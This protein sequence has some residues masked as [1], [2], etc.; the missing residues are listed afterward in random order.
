MIV[1]DKVLLCG[2]TRESSAEI[3]QWVNQPELKELTGTIY[4]ISDYE[5]D[6]WMEARATSKSDRLFLI[7]DKETQVNI[8]TIGL[9]HIDL[10]TAMQNC[11]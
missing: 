6:R 1:G 8:G 5:H 4:P 9:K 11:I 3:L 2:L 7:K 10:S